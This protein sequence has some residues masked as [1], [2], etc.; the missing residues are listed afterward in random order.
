MK[1]PK[2]VT[3]KE[4]W[5]GSAVAVMNEVGRIESVRF[6][7]SPWWLSAVWRSWD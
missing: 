1:D 4:L 6:I 2:F 3:Y 5:L 7:E